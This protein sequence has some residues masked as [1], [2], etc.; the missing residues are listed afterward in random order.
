[1]RLLL[2]S[3]QHAVPKLLKDRVHL[4]SGLPGHTSRQSA[5]SESKAWKGD[6]QENCESQRAA[7]GAAM[8]A[9]VAPEFPRG[10]GD[11]QAPDLLTFYDLNGE[12]PTFS[13]L[14]PLSAQLLNPAIASALAIP[15][16]GGAASPTAQAQGPSAQQ[17]AQQHS[18][19]A[20]AAAAQMQGFQF[21][22]DYGAM[23]QQF[24]H[25]GMPQA[26]QYAAAQQLGQLQGG[27]AQGMGQLGSGGAQGPAGFQ[28]MQQMGVTPQGQP[29]YGWPS[30]HDAGAG[31]AVP[32]ILGQSTSR[33]VRRVRIEANAGPILY[34]ASAAGGYGQLQYSGWQDQGAPKGQAQ[35]QQRAQRPPA[36]GVSGAR[37]A[38]FP[39]FYG[40]RQET[41]L[42]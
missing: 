10:N 22:A 31:K 20:Q 16:E 40:C 21:P 34:F 17:L 33:F 35:E 32:Q 39:P 25:A 18:A 3:M 8:M 30:P 14:T 4:I 29:L 28:Q 19:A 12:L 13:D 37:A 15:L 26:Q 7:T 9:G 27:Y 5:P 11:A 24:G 41:Q 36:S 42:K 6:R 2:V 1:M 23:A 38:H